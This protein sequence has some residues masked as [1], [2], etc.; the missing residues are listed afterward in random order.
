M[1][2]FGLGEWVLILLI[3]LLLFGPRWFVKAGS[4]LGESF[5]GFTRGLKAGQQPPVEPG[6][7]PALPERQETP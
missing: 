4:T 6:T 2:G 3:A 5:A 7:R 1:F